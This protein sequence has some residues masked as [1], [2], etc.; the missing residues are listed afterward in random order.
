MPAPCPVPFDPWSPVGYQVV[1]VSE[2]KTLPAEGGGPKKVKGRTARSPLGYRVN[3]VADEEIP[4]PPRPKLQWSLRRQ[5]PKTRPALIWAPIAAGGFFF[6]LPV[7]A[8]AFSIANQAQQPPPRHFVQAPQF[9]PAP[10]P[11]PAQVVIPEEL[12]KPPPANLQ[13]NANAL[14]PQ[15][16]A[17]DRP[18]PKDGEGCETFG[19]SMEFVRNPQVA[20]KMATED[21]KLTFLLHVSGNFEDSR[22]T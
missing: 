22:F 21:G 7:L 19:T 9:D 15:P 18:A 10:A 16:I 6:L 13:Q 4:V 20:A 14:V 2:E 17:K 11:P 3:V 12:F 1:Q 8:I 5:P